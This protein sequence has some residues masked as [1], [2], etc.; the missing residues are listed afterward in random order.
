MAATKPVAKEPSPVEQL[1]KVLSAESVQEQF[2]N[3]LKEE[4]PLFVASLIDIYSNDKTLQ[5]CKP[6]DVVREALK[7]A[8]LKLPINKNLGFAWIIPYKEKGVPKP[9]FQLGYKGYIQLAMRTGQYK[10]L[11]ADVVYEGEIVYHDKLTGELR[12][13]RSDSDEVIGYF[14]HM[15]TINGFRKTIYWTKEQMLN[16]AKRFSASFHREHSPWKTDFEAMA[17]KTM[18]K[19]LLSRYGI[20][21][22]DM[23]NAFTADSAD[24]GPFEDRVAGEIEANANSEILDIDAEDAEDGPD[25]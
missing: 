20:M 8:T 23:M 5:E 25:W 13:E 10:Y 22:I 1:K 24:D 9:Q 14:A 18:L 6:G 4:A 21:S 11:N 17:I 16:H 12:L 15:E 7:A 19:A 2:R 3:A